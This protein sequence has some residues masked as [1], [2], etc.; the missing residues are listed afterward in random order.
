MV[1]FVLLMVACG[2]KS[3]S[4]QQTVEEVQAQES[5]EAKNLLQG[6]WVDEDTEEPSFRVVGDTIFYPDS[7]SQPVYFAIIGDSLVLS[8]INAKYLVVKQSPHVFWFRNQNGD[9]VKLQKSDD[10]I[11]LFAFVHD[12]PQVLTYTEVV[13]KDS[14]VFYDAKRYHWYLAI[15]PT[16]YKVHIT[17]YNSDGVEVDNVYFDNIMHISVFEGSRQLYSSDFRKQLYTKQ[18]PAEFLEKAVLSNMEYT[19]VDKRGF[20]F[21]ATICIPDGASC[22]KAENI[23][24]FDGRLSTT[25]IEY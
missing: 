5:R 24:S 23:I 22:Y 15:N 4:S 14:V 13:K 1:V 2:S 17:S 3:G 10:P 21:V 9:L 25:L 11:H 12:R 18:I 16:K 8:D 7:I 6:I 20:R 19:G